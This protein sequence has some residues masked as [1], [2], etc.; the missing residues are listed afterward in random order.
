MQQIAKCLAAFEH[1]GKEY[2]EGDCFDAKSLTENDRR[3]LIDQG[4]IEIEDVPD[5]PGER[6]GCLDYWKGKGVP[7]AEPV[8]SVATQP[9][10]A[11]R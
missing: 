8:Q 4:K 2:G 7:G 11:R 3:I 9:K 10:R 6:I 1:G 5:R